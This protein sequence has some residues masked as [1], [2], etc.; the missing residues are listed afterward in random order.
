MHYYCIFTYICRQTFGFKTL[1]PVCL[2]YTQASFN[3]LW[4]PSFPIKTR[5]T[6]PVPAYSQQYYCTFYVLDY[7]RFLVELSVNTKAWIRVNKLPSIIFLNIRRD[8][9]NKQVT[10]N[11]INCVHKC[12]GNSISLLLQVKES[13]WGFS[14]NSPLPAVKPAQ[15]VQLLQGNLSPAG[16]TRQST[17]PGSVL[18]SWIAIA[19]VTAAAEEN[20]RKSKNR[21]YQR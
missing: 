15:V 6:E 17:F 14:W 12:F 19:A 7:L 18:R 11:V 16:T 13:I 9:A 1:P 21:S 3:I 20:L 10:F 5:K 8:L 4:D 2:L